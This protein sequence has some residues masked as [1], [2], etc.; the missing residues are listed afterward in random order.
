MPR[1]DYHCAHNGR[2]VEV[3]HSMK[4][5]LTTWGEVCAITLEPLGD[6]PADAPVERWIPRAVGVAAPM[7]DSRL[8]EL[9]FTK[10]VKRDNGVYENVTRLD[11][12][13]RYMKRDDPTTIPDFKR[14]IKD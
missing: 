2:T 13:S 7:G 11:G 1:Y 4:D 5:D 9:G 6:T 3:S 12:E 8:K 14:R 10:L